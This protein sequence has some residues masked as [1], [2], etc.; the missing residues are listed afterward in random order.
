[1]AI[2]IR[3]QHPV[4]NV[5]NKWIPPRICQQQTSYICTESPNNIKTHRPDSGEGRTELHKKSVSSL[6]KV[7][8]EICFGVRVMKKGIKK[9]ANEAARSLRNIQLMRKA[10]HEIVK[11]PA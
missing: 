6:S 2:N 4:N 7:V 11:L 8:A 3:V 9:K 10:V 1:M 5:S